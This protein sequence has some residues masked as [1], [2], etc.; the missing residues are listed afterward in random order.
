MEKMK[1]KKELETKYSDF[2]IERNGENFE[3]DLKNF[4]KEFNTDVKCYK[5]IKSEPLEININ[6]K[7]I[8]TSNTNLSTI[9]SHSGYKVERDI[10]KEVKENYD[11]KH[12]I[13][14]ECKVVLKKLKIEVK[15]ED[16]KEIFHLPDDDE[17]VLYVNNEFFTPNENFNTNEMDI[18][19]EE[20]KQI[21]KY[22]IQH[23]S[24]KE[25]HYNYNIKTKKCVYSSRKCNKIHEKIKRK[26]F[27]I[28]FA[29]HS[30]EE[31]T[32][33]LC[34]QTFTNKRIL[35]THLFCHIR[36]KP[37]RC[38]ICNKKFLWQF[39]L[40]RH[41]KEHKTGNENE[42]SHWNLRLQPSENRVNSSPRNSKI[43]TCK[44]CGKEFKCEFRLLHHEA[45][46]GEKR[47]FKCD[48][49]NK[50]FKWKHQLKSHDVTHTD[51]R[52]HTC[53]IC[54][55][56]F[57]RSSG[58]KQHINNIHSDEYK[59]SCDTCNKY[60]KTKQYLRQHKR[61]HN[62]K[63]NIKRK[64]VYCNIC[65]KR[66]PY[67]KGRLE[68]HKRIH[69]THACKICGKEFK[70]KYV[71]LRHGARHSE[72]R[73]FKCDICNKGF[74]WKCQAKS[75]C[76]THTDKVNYTCHICNKSFKCSYVLKQHI[77]THSDEYKYSCDICNKHFKTKNYLSQHKYIHGKKCNIKRENVYCNI[78]G[79]RVRYGKG[80]LERHMRTHR[81]Y[82][83]E[84]CGK[85]FNWKCN[86]LHHEAM[87]SE[88]SPYKCDIC[89]KSFKW[90]ENLK[91]HY[92]THTD[93]R[94]Y[95][96]QVCNKRFKTK[97]HLASHKVVHNDEFNHTCQVCNK[98]FKRSSELKVH[99]RTHTDEYKYSCDMCNKYF[100]KKNLLCDSIKLFIQKSTFVT[101]VKKVTLIQLL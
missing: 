12:G 31:F 9:W 85:E 29:S 35:Q 46:H 83:C 57:K 45:T 33:D 48:I 72:E 65:G 93:E 43:H 94:N 58:L 101:Y 80:R 23:N 92:E 25:Q 88:D 19:I 27:R 87:H 24:K 68:I 55:K 3:V 74:K 20:E 86:L 30:K 97:K 2:T 53:H 37:F 61:I 95:V 18:Q 98:S 28:I 38:T 40:R 10:K 14:S 7:Q 22:D 89:N 91:M 60:F 34:K 11:V 26:Y 47:P 69:K 81:P 5:T 62:K 77:E 17:H 6:G 39:L 100:K 32:C 64:N 66:V 71:L 79:K 50:G 84:I 78:C 44:I 96:C 99:I 63:S 21:Q 56:S 15:T 41:T 42:M 67:G 54:N 82:A 90:K 1:I 36:K 76:E 70:W 4:K 16:H 8:S 51:E 59:Y 75:H 73:P 52:N 13:K 49:C